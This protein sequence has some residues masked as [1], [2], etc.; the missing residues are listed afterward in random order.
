MCA[1]F[2]VLVR[3]LGINLYVNEPLPPKPYNWPLSVDIEHDESGGF[4]G[5]GVY[6]SWTN[7]HYWYT[8]PLALDSDSL[9]SVPLVLHNGV[10]D[11][12]VLRTWGFRVDDSQIAY[13]TMLMGHILD[14]SLKAYGL[15]DMVKR[16]LGIEYPDY[17]AIVGK[18]TEK[19]KA[20]R[21]T[22]DKQPPRLVQL[23]NCM[24]TVVTQKEM[25]YQLGRLY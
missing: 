10:S 8:D 11:L 24:D 17:D 4:V 25:E 7:S 6:C 21:I 18:R 20:E 12:D 1:T 13:D 9:S 5:V 19:Q 3:D 16:D 14:S 23:Y 2:E 22:L 15:K